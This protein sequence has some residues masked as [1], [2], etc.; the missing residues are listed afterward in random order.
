MGFHQ[1]QHISPNGNID[2]STHKGETSLVT[3][4]NMIDD[5]SSK[6][7]KKDIHHHSQQ[8]KMDHNE[9]KPKVMPKRILKR[10]FSPSGDVRCYNFQKLRNFAANFRT[11]Q[12]EK[13]WYNKPYQEQNKGRQPPSR[14]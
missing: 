13:Q 12:Q 8:S 9:D 2:C 3:A 1:G 5:N 4:T 6:R 14:N 10:S 7:S 11:M